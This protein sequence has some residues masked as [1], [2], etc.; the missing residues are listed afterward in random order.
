MK[1]TFLLMAIFGTALFAK[2]TLETQSHL[3]QQL[4]NRPQFLQ[5]Y[6]RL[7]ERG[8]P[9]DEI[10]EMIH[11]EE[12][13]I[14]EP[15]V[16]PVPEPP[17]LQQN[18]TNPALGQGTQTTAP[19]IFNDHNLELAV[20]SA[21]GKPDGEITTADMETLI[22][23]YAKN[24]K[25]VDL[26]GLEYAENLISL[27]LNGNQINNITPLRNLTGLT[28]LNLGN[29]LIHDITPIQN[30][31]KISSLYLQ[32]NQIRNIRVLENL[33]NLIYLCLNF[34]QIQDITALTHLTELEWLN[35]EDNQISDIS[36]LENK[37]NLVYLNLAS[38]KIVD[39]TA[40]R[41]LTRLNDLYVHNNQIANISALAQL[42]ELKFLRLDRN[43]IS[44]LNALQNLRKLTKVYLNVNQIQDVSSLAY[45]TKINFLQLSFNQISDISGL[46]MLTKLTNLYL[47]YNEIKNISPIRDLPE[48]DFLHLANNKITSINALQNLTNLTFL[49]L[50]ENQIEDLS[51][52]QNLTRLKT[53]HL[54]ANQV[55]NLK[56]LE[57]LRSLS[58][59]F[60]H[61]NRI[62]DIR[63][64]A[65]LDSLTFL[66][67]SGNQIID[68][69][70]LK[71]LTELTTLRLGMNQIFDLTLLQNLD[72]LTFLQLGDNKIRD[73]SPLLNLT[74]LTTLWLY[75][76]QIRDISALS[77]KTKLKMLRLEYNQISDLADLKNLIQLK[78]LNLSTNQLANAD[79]TNLYKM[80]ELNSLNL[81]INPGINNGMAVQTLADN[82]DNL[83][84]AQIKWDGI[85][86]AEP[87]PEPTAVIDVTIPNPA[88]IDQTVK[89][90]AI[91]NDCNDDSVQMRIKWGDGTISEYSGYQPSG[92][93]FVFEHKYTTQDE[94]Q[95]RVLA[96]DNQGIKGV[97]S[98]AVQLQVWV[99]N[100]PIITSPH[101]VT[102]LE[103][104]LLH[105]TASATDPEN[106]KISYSFENYPSWLS[107]YDSTI[108]GI[109]T[110][111]KTD[112]SFVLIA[113]DQILRDTLE[114]RVKVI[115]VNDPPEIKNL[116]GFDLTAKEQHF[117]DLYE[118]VDD[119]DHPDSLLIWNILPESDKLTVVH[120][121]HIA[122]FTATDDFTETN[123]L[124]FVTDPLGAADTLTV[125][126]Q[127]TGITS[128]TYEQ[129]IPKHFCMDPNYPNPFNPKTNI[130][131]GLPKAASIT[132][133]IYDIKG[134]KIGALFS[135]KKPA[136]YHN[137][138]WDATHQASGV[139]F[140]HFIAPGFVKTQK[141][142]L[143]K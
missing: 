62:Y 124:F 56:A 13:H 119:P 141:C 111:G 91:G 92:S 121:H 120:D 6:Y 96:R 138:V 65:N 136:G 57:N 76:N 22:M 69:S 43:E 35:L 104:S 15:Q 40:I 135:G 101:S 48:L 112:T 129:R 17:S 14:L 98:N 34:N 102:V 44:N 5:S 68:I 94:Y 116:A 82:L 95:V 33:A 128:K 70:P 19:V 29:N 72:K 39:I 109:P 134:R 117:I 113:F 27:N 7:L 85:C 31:T 3:L 80:D 45:L 38:N 61:Y 93:V 11:Q 97:W 86:G 55:I 103:D 28:F 100:P 26:T 9:P 71:K 122:K 81:R 107:P 10:E 77:N 60:L 52:L 63:A 1:S 51:P 30:L 36:A 105:Y 46:G 115:P 59:L 49:Y 41:N 66:H 139:Y 50:G 18:Q 130:Q 89:V 42:T 140:I 25:I 58:Q 78:D 74:E 16:A 110:E 12:K 88:G 54:Y 20:R 108:S 143:I 99:D 4:K 24:S 79:L 8:I 133:C 87:G 23:L 132:I 84:C 47:H 75:Q 127:L 123:I 83:T 118:C 126:V 131:F 37:N 90:E 2:S 73:I 64:L 21:L 53:L 114:V 137:I 32:Y 142:I 67:L 106:R 125:P